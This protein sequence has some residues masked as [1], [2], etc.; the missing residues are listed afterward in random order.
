MSDELAR[1][2]AFEEAHRERAVDRVVRCRFGHAF[3]TDPLPLVWDLNLVSLGEA[4]DASAG[5][6]AEEAERVHSAAG[7]AHRRIV[8]VREPDARRLAPELG[9]LGW[10]TDRF[11]FM[12]DRRNAA[13]APSARVEE[14]AR[15]TVA[16]LREAFTRDSPWATSEEV[17]EQVL[18][19]RARFA[20]AGN[21]RHF[22]VREGGGIAAC[23]DLYSDGR[24][25]QIEEVVTLPEFRGRGYASAVVLRALAAA[26][27]TGHDFLFLVADEDD[28]P[29]E[30]YAKLGFE[31]IGRTYSFLKPPPDLG[32]APSGGSQTRT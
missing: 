11:L 24:T 13:R 4:G 10:K 31:P 26:R 29:K 3:L 14:V 16:P 9:E 5:D 17:V 28:W 25:A 2:V 6:I 27:E 30:L 8:V 21:A 20:A 19:G 15:D 32:R 23:A 22:A 7:H 12:A 1:A 18:A